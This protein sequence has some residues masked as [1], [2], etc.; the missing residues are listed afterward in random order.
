MT[1]ISALGGLEILDSRGRP[2]VQA[3]CRLASGAIGTASAP[4]GASTGAAEAHELRDG[5]A[6]RY[7]GLGCRRAVRHINGEL[8]QA[9][10]G[11]DL[12]DQA[13]LDRQLCALDGTAHKSRLGANAILAVS[14]AFARA[15]AVERQQPLYAYF[16]SLLARPLSPRLPRPTINLF[17]GGKHA[18]GQAPIQ[19]IL[20]VAA[21]AQTVDEALSTTVAVFHA[22]AELCQEKYQMRLLTADE[23]GLAPPFTNAEAMLADAVTAIE[24]AGYRPGLDVC[25]AVD[26][27]SSHF[28]HEGA[29]HLDKQQLSSQAM[30]EQLADWVARYPIVSVEDGLAEE[31]WAHWPLLRQR[32]GANVL[33]L[34]DDFLCTNPDR[35]RRA[36]ATSAATALLLKVNQIGTLTEAAEAYQLARDAG[37]QVTISARSGETED[38]WL[39]DLAVGWRGDQ[40]K[41]GSITQSERLAKYNRLLAIEAETGWSMVGWPNQ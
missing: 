22:A 31:D 3:T 34:G 5:D 27:A 26:V 28:Y 32:L 29:Y 21:A 39:A 20:V 7:R 38:N 40:L 8:A 33:V 25:L 13:Q 23:G 41:V 30:I 1:R 12:V 11:V 19:D 16:S 9:L 2:T 6:T 37:W 17:S 10:I 4:S 15:A 18:G 14:L 35:I 24:R 36:V